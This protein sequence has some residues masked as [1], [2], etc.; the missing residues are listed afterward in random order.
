MS[1]LNFYYGWE[2]VLALR[3]ALALIL[4]VHGWPKIAHPGATAKSFD[5]MGFRP[6]LLWGAIA[7]L[8]EFAGG[9]LLALGL[10]T[11]CVASLLAAQ[12]LVILVWRLA[13]RQHFVGG[14]EFDLLI[15]AAA[16]FFVLHGAG[17]YSLDGAYFIGW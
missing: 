14:W 3:L 11:F 15:F 9:I 12:F 13:T 8:I 5:G 2:G 17:S 10:F 4:I 6:G 16:I 7:G 1:S